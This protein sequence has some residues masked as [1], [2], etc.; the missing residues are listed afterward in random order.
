MKLHLVW[1]P[2]PPR[3]LPQE[4]EGG[5]VNVSPT[6]ALAKVRKV[7]GPVLT[8]RLFNSFY[9]DCLIGVRAGR[10]YQT[11]KWV[12]EFCVMTY[13]LPNEN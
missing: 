3:A 8:T 11:V 7:K 1:C 10:V 12:M 9:T 6:S 5:Q 4:I 13:I 2:L